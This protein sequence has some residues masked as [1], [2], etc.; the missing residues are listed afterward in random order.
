MRE[1]LSNFRQGDFV[2]SKLIGR[3]EVQQA[4]SIKYSFEGALHTEDGFLQFH[5]RTSEFDERFQ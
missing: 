4:T 5:I 1:P 2:A 3:F